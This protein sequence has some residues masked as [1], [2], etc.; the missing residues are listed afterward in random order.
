MTAPLLSVRDLRTW[1]HTSSGIARAVD[2]VSFDVMPHETVGVVGE[3]GCGKSVTSLAIMRLLPRRGNSVTGVVEFEG[4][5]LL[6]LP[7][8]DMRDRR[9]RDLAMIFQDPL[10]SLNP[11]V[12]PVR[13]DDLVPDRV[14]R[15][16]R[17]QRILEDHRHLGAAQ[18]P[19][20]L[21]RRAD[22]LLAVQPDL[23]GDLRVA[24][25][26]QAQDAQAGDRLTGTRLADDAQR[27]AALQPERQPVDA[28]DQAVVGRERDLQ[29]L[30]LE[31]GFGCH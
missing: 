4:T 7:L 9:G 13:L 5:D 6:S 14:E 10:S 20:G 26:V 15:V 12:H 1:F 18:G 25:V 31:E 8:N 27:L 19:Y 17:G 16:H 11:V 2:G 28:L 3:S 22:E 23:A 30:D 21:R 24:L 29:V